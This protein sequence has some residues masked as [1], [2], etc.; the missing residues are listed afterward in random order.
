VAVHAKLAVLVVQVLPAGRTCA[1]VRRSAVALVV[2]ERM[3]RAGCSGAATRRGDHPQRT[4]NAAPL[5]PA[6]VRGM[7]SDAELKTTH[8]T[9]MM[10]IARELAIAAP[11]DRH[12]RILA[13]HVTLH[14][15]S[16]QR[17]AHRWMAEFTR[18]ARGTPQAKALRRLRQ[19][20]AR[21]KEIRDRIATRRQAA[22]RS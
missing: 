4:L 10:L 14:G 8:A 1:G 5:R 3:T 2:R 12:Q 17:W 19:A 21:Q 6:T 9:R 13:R 18:P 15:D 16:V 22:A 11:T 7:V 20:Y